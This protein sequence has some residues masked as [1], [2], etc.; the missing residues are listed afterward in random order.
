MC[1]VIHTLGGHRRLLVGVSDRQRLQGQL[2]EFQYVWADSGLPLDALQGEP[3]EEGGSLDAAGTQATLTRS[4][5]SHAAVGTT[6]GSCAG[7]G[8]A[9]AILLQ[10]T[11]TTKHTTTAAHWRLLMDVVGLIM[12]LSH[13]HTY[14]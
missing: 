14:T 11:T 3:R 1:E 7:G 8:P 4:S 12:H 6:T 9:G 10:P 13:P 5:S 2:Q